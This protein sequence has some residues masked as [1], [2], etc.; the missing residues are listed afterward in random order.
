MALPQRYQMPSI[1]WGFARDSGR[2]LAEIS[3]DAVRYRQSA[4]TGNLSEVILSDERVP[5]VLQELLGC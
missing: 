2:I 1:Q 3:H 5:M 4:L